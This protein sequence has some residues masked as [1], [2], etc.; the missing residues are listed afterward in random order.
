M[1]YGKFCCCKF[2]SVTESCSCTG[3]RPMLQCVNFVF[4][5]EFISLQINALLCAIR[6]KWPL[7]TVSISNTA[8]I[9]S[10]MRGIE[11]EHLGGPRISKVNGCMYLQC[12][13]VLFVTC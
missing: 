12:V 1:L 2:D 4:S 7:N 11:A 3:F 6:D 8:L 10:K 13:S 9:D 5:V